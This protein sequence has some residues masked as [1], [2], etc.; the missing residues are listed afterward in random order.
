MSERIKVLDASYV[1]CQVSLYYWLIYITFHFLF[2]LFV[3]LLRLRTQE[4][5]DLMLPEY[6]HVPPTSTHAKF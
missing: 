3:Y 5:E 4:K 1:E 6:I 2:L